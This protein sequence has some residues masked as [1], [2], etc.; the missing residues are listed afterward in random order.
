MIRNRTSA[1]S[2]GLWLVGRGRV[3]RSIISSGGQSLS[4]LGLLALVLMP[5]SG[6]GIIR[7]LSGGDIANQIN[8]HRFYLKDDMEQLRESQFPERPLVRFHDSPYTA[9]EWVSRDAQMAWLQE[10]VVV[11]ARDLPLE[12]LM[13]QVMLQIED[14]PL[15]LYGIADEQVQAKGLRVAIK[16][17]AGNKRLAGELE[18]L[19][20]GDSWLDA[21]RPVTL[22][23]EGTVQEM[24][25]R[26]TQLTD[27]A[28]TV[29]AEGEALH[30]HAY[31]T[32]SFRMMHP[33]GDQDYDIGSSGGGG[34]NAGV[35]SGGGGSIS[36]SFGSSNQFVGFEENGG[37]FWDDLQSA[38][39]AILDGEGSQEQY[40]SRA[41]ISVTA[42]AAK[43]LAVERFINDLNT[44]MQ[45]KMIIEFRVIEVT[46]ND[47]HS[48]GVDWSVVQSRLLG[49]DVSVA[50]AGDALTI[51]SSN[52][53][54]HISGSADGSHYISSVLTAL[55]SQGEVS[56]ETAPRALV[57][58]HQAVEVKRSETLSYISEI[59]RNVD[60]FGSNVVFEPGTIES[61]V[62]F[63]ALV[64]ILDSRR[65]VLQVTGT[66]R[67][68]TIGAAIDVGNG[69][70]VNLPS[71][72]ENVFNQRAML[73][74]GESL[75]L[76][77]LR[78]R[79]GNYGKTANTDFDINKNQNWAEVETIVMIT[80]VVINN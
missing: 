10:R 20:S 39:D 46:L 64:N 54:E 48:F 52:T 22:D 16:K 45:R 36:A 76:S 19:M 35:Q 23:F 7:S 71:L 68:A 4:V 28:Y 53:P 37:E 63:Y 75:V 27:Y 21:G 44:D 6:C 59:S 30:W 13:N 25:D 38:V 18:Q 43:V 17:E 47:A 55:R 72:T 41:T 9:F 70:Q 24:L 8:E 42:P 66:L 69:S 57:Y 15:I 58:N 12:W 11:N 51:A 1:A 50:F 80:P 32:R 56:V 40:I 67:E 49:S 61:G 74:S 2:A 26:V 79:R 33:Q 60:S 65:V 77:G 31:L 78:R 3:V 73:Q 29:E 14:A 34:G 62:S 5:L